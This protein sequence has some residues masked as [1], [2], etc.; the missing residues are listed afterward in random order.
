MPLSLLS[1]AGRLR[2]LVMVIITISSSSKVC[3][4]VGRIERF[5]AADLQHRK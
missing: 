2:M 3:V 4:Y 5:A 1:A